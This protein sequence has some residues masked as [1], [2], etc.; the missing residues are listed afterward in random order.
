MSTAQAPAAGARAANTPAAGRK[1]APDLPRA[2]KV[3]VLTLLKHFYDEQ[4]FNLL[5]RYF[6]DPDPEVS[7]AAIASSGSIGNDAAIP[8]LYRL[9]EQG[10]TDQKIAAIRTLAAINAPAAIENLYKYF[11]HFRQTEIR[12]E[13]LKAINR[14]SPLHPKSRELNVAVLMDTGLGKGYDEPILL[15][16]L[17][18]GEFEHVKNNLL[19]TQPEVQ[20]LIFNKI[21]EMTGEEPGNFVEH[22]QNK[23]GQLDPTTLGFFLCA[24]ELKTT[25]PQQNYVV[26]TL[27]SV[28]ARATTS[29]LLS[30]TN[31]KGRI[32]NLSRMFRLLLRVPYVDPDTEGLNGDLLARII[33]EVRT[34]SP[35]LLNEF[36]F[37]TAT[38][39][40]AVF[41]KIRQQTVSLQGVKQKE[42]L[43]AVLLAKALEQYGT[44]ELLQEAAG[45][46]KIDSNDDPGPLVT[47]I[48]ERMIWA[49]EDERNRFEATR[50]LFDN[51]DRSV[52]LNTYH[53]LAKVNQHNPAL[54]RRLNR[55]IR[56]IGTLDIRN[57]GK[58]ILEILNYSRQERIPYLEQ[59]CVVTLCQLL[60]RTAIEQAKNFFAEPA[61][62]AHSVAG[63]VRG[64]RYL[65]PKLFLNP[66]L[67][68]LG[69]PKV[70]P[71]IQGVIVNSLEAM[72]LGGIAGVLPPLIKAMRLPHVSQD[73]KR[74]L[75][76]IIA[77]YGDS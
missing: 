11:A 27:Q 23:V 36:I 41:A 44:A 14:I 32:Q 30:L 68:L 59:T 56:V 50:Q 38:N 20:R 37:A 52:R 64:A 43:L 49:S 21:L 19:G 28:D 31:H 24:Y 45:F 1:D 17:E 15:G 5:I 74:H 25:S 35:L 8:H 9:A 34:D 33:A 54:M 55:L 40:E 48:R 75:S 65:P 6:Y 60:N 73:N 71:R 67:R 26:D 7:K 69:D 66:M 22:F 39:L 76:S 77:R 61:K 3:T 10:N 42:A 29:F 16:L 4:I 18:A 62:N 2:V 12:R 47:R 70:G 46:F 13:I 58:K 57:S 51:D 72:E 53:T 63:Y